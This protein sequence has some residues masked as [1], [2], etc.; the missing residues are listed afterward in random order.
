MV[1]RGRGGREEREGGSG[2]LTCACVWPPP[3]PGSTVGSA[4][5]TKFHF[6]I[7]GYLGVQMA[8]AA[9][10]ESGTER[11]DAVTSHG[12]C[13][14]SQRHFS[15]MFAIAP[16]RASGVHGD[17]DVSIRPSAKQKEPKQERPIFLETS[18]TTRMK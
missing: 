6:G 9:D 2:R 16:C 1:G 7:A 15:A 12:G 13:V 10:G 3:R 11:G 14:T 18:T 8:E 17:K 4:N 5:A